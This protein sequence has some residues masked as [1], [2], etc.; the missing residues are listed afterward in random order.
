MQANRSCVSSAVGNYIQNDYFTVMSPWIAAARLKTLPAAVAPVLVGSAL[1]YNDGGFHF[2][3][4]ALCLCFALL[5]QIGTNYANDYYDFL[6]GADTAE[7]VGPARMVAAGKIAPRQM[8]VA[9]WVVFGGAFAVGCGLLPYGGW[10]LLIV[11]VSSI[12]CGIAY[13]GGPYPL[14]YHGWGDVFVFLFFGIVAVGC[15][16]FVQTGYYSMAAFWLSLAPGVLSTNLLVVNNYRDALTDVKA[17]KR[18]LAVRFGRPFALVQY[19]VMLTIACVLVPVGLV[20]ADVA[21]MPMLVLALLVIPGATQMKALRQAAT[22]KQYNQVLANT[23]KLLLAHSVLVAALL[24][25]FC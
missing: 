12:V 18:T 25:V 24:V 6:K 14:G 16:Y 5:I 7:R 11:G 8:F 9:M 20:L 19:G 23:A 2:L 1:A 21:F 3:P 10:P 22:P 15:T 13:T 4:A 17:G